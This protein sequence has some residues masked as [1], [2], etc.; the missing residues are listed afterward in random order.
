MAGVSGGSA[1]REAEPGRAETE[2][3][4]RARAGA[5]LSMVG[6]GKRRT[7]CRAVDGQG[8]RPPGSRHTAA[9]GV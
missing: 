1:E 3:G 9:N 7:V 2:A 8:I 6:G 5:D 4:P